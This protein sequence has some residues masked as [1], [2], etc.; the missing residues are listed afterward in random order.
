ME[1]PMNR[2]D[3]P[4]VMDGNALLKA[5]ESTIMSRRSIRVAAHAGILE[6]RW[7]GGSLARASTPSPGRYTSSRGSLRTVFCAAIQRVDGDSTL[8]EICTDEWGYYPREW[9]SPYLEGELS[10]G[11]ST[12]CLEIE[13]GDKERMQAQFSR[14]YRFF[15]APVGL[16]LH[17]PPHHAAGWTA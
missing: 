11:G 9:I 1:A 12:G 10:V 13:K 3:T 6:R 2:V 16:I 8:D 4:A 5:V 17:H 14:N 15:D 7:N